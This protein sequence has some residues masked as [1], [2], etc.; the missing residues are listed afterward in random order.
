MTRLVGIDPGTTAGLICLD[1][2]PGSWSLW[3][4]RV[5]GTRT[6][7]RTSSKKL[8]D[9]EK[10]I[11]FRLTLAHQ[12]LDWAPTDVALEC[13]RDIS[14]G[15]GSGG[16]R[17]G[18]AFR[19][20]AMYAAALFAIP[21]GVRIG[22]ALVR[23]SSKLGKGWRGWGDKEKKLHDVRRLGEALGLDLSDTPH[24]VDALGVADFY[25]KQQEADGAP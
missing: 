3:D 20:G 18:T 16:R 23:G 9:A 7:T 5:V 1:L 10:D 6:I 11:H 22:T 12:L 4:A 24:L 2:A 13:P 19:L 17:V 15:W 21:P 8:S 14:D 25:T